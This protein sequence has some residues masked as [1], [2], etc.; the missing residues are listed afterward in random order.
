MVILIR[1]QKDFFLLLLI[2][3]YLTR[4]QVQ[5]FLPF[6]NLVRFQVINY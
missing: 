2:L 3:N 6:E 4:H 1:H 5:S